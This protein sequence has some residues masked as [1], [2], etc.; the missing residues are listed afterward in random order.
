MYLKLQEQDLNQLNTNGDSD[1]VASHEA[2]IGDSD[3]KKGK[4]Y[5][6]SRKVASFDKW[7]NPIRKHGA[8]AGVVDRHSTRT[9]IFDMYF[10]SKVS[11]RR[12]QRVLQSQV[13][14]NKVP[15][16]VTTLRIELGQSI[17]HCLNLQRCGT[18]RTLLVHDDGYTLI[19]T[20]KITRQYFRKSIRWI[21]VDMSYDQ[22]KAMWDTV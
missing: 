18:I 4:D 12:Y 13:D 14:D 10:L 22:V 2:A 11:Y 19:N 7:A 21:L 8:T 5:Y 15:S 17:F 16:T 20:R 3:R 1:S 6:R 9:Q